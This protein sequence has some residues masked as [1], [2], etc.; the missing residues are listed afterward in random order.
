M[1]A[2]EQAARPR[3][4]MNALYMGFSVGLLVGFF[5]L[6]YVVISIWNPLA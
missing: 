2:L 4:E 5:F 6:I 1:V 3:E